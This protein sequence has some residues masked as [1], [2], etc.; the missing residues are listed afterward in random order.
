[1]AEP[2]HEAPKSGTNEQPPGFD[3]AKLFN[4]FSMVFAEFKEY[5]SYLISLELD[6]VKYKLA[7]LVM[8]VIAG[9]LAFVAVL[10]LFVGSLLLLL[11]GI[12]G[13]IGFFLGNFWFGAAI[14][15]L[16]FVGISSGCVLYAR[17]Y[18]KTHFITELAEKYAKRRQKQKERFGRDIQEVSGV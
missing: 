5:I 1:M 16:V 6:R 2:N 17:Y 7:M 18:L 8:L 13:T 9:I 14:V 15:G 4:D 10:V 11:L 3:T 12:A